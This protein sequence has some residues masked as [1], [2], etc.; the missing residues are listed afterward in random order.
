MVTLILGSLNNHNYN[1]NKI[2]Q[3]C[4]NKNNCFSSGQD[5]VQSCGANQK[6]ELG[7]VTG[8]I[9]N[10]IR[11]CSAEFLPNLITAVYAI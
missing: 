8:L 11:G 1:G 4:K 3:S 7:G 10:E 9:E 5:S 6:S 2:T